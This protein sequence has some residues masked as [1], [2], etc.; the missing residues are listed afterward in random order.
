MKA[1]TKGPIVSPRPI[2]VV[3]EAIS[4]PIFDAIKDRILD[5]ELR[6]GTKLSEEEIASI[7][8]VGRT[9]ARQSLRLL[10]AIGIVTIHKNRGAFVSSP[11]R[12]EAAQTY[13]ARRMLECPAVALV[14]E[15]RSSENV[16]ALRS[17]LDHQRFEMTRNNRSGFLRAT[18][19][20]H[21]LMASMASNPVVEMLIN[22]LL[23][24]AALISTLYEPET[25][26]VQAVEDHTRLVK[27]IASRDSAGASKFM[28]THLRRVEAW[29]EI[30]PEEE[31]KTDLRSLL[32]PDRG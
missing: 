23:A 7:F 14:A 26:S 4:D 2:V 15:T 8:S 19:E 25:P 12:A 24:R 20:F 30:V 21:S 32:R 13:A 31:V 16:I 11:T 9:R 29:L 28:E 10:A 6:P 18:L 5:G 3:R 22:Q 1:T 17:H 27:L